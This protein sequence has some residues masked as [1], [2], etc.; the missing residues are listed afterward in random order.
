MA[1]EHLVDQSNIVVPGSNFT[2]QIPGCRSSGI[3]Q[4]WEKS[5]RVEAAYNRINSSPGANVSQTYTSDSSIVRVATVLLE[6]LTNGPSYEV[7][8]IF[9]W[10][11]I[12]SSSPANVKC[13]S[14]N[15][16]EYAYAM[17]HYR[18]RQVQQLILLLRL[19][20]YHIPQCNTI[21][22]QTQVHLDLYCLHCPIPIQ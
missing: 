3:P 22:P 8:S 20:Q 17:V 19:Q 14:S 1:L 4:T 7:Y 2:T 9:L 6:R 11:D 5:Q 12:V 21:P 18:L 16:E 13:V 15:P 10:T